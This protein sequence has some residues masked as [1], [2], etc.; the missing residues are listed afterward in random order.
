MRNI[1]KTILLSAA[2]LAA[3]Q[4]CVSG[5]SYYGQSFGDPSVYPQYPQYV[6]YPEGAPPVAPAMP[7][8]EAALSDDQIDQLLS[9]VALYPD[10]LLSLIFPAATYPQDVAAAEQWLQATPNPTEEAINAQPWD[11][12]IK[13]LV[14]YPTVLKMMSD[15]MDW[16][17]AL[18]AAF[19]NQQQDVMDSVQRL[20]AAAQNAQ[21][22]RSTDQQQVLADEGA[23]RIE[24]VNPQVIYV[25]QYDPAIVYSQ[26]CPIYWGSG[27]RLGDWCDNDFDWG[28][29]FI[30]V[31]GGWFSHWHHPD[32]WDHH[33]GDWDHHPGN[34]HPD[35]HRWTRT[36]LRPAP[37]LTPQVITRTGLD[38][39]RVSPA[40]RPEGAV[41]QATPPARI[42]N[43]AGRIGSQPGRT[44]PGSV[45]VPQNRDSA[46]R[47][48]N[49]GRGD[50]T[51]TSTGIRN[52]APATVTPTAPATPARP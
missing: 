26:P 32:D 11:P 6:Q 36:P 12:S 33:R 47:E 10:P 30:I 46:T 1:W 7:A 49:R 39:P 16:T 9:P 8:G 42:G 43:P 3:T 48:G 28:S 15:Q 37:R 34:W 23:I 25:P 14:H 13:G 31:G 38:H 44:T 2:C 27:Y 51:D 18:G 21:N 29:H 24:P 52:R 17:N 20:R 35:P 50:R 19:I 5:Q 4:S 45:F 22:L 40:R 41:R